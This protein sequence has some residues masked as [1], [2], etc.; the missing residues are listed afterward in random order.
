MIDKIKGWINS[1][2]QKATLFGSIALVMLL[3]IVTISV[4]VRFVG[5][6]ISYE[7]L[8]KK[9]ENATYRYLTEN[10]NNLPSS[11]NPTVAISATTLIEQNYLKELKKYVKDPSC[12][13]NVLVDY[14][15]NDYKYQAYL[16][17]SEFKTEKFVDKIKA[18][19]KISQMGEGLYEMNNELVFRGQN[20]NNFISFA[21]EL[22]RI[23]KI[24]KNN[25]IQM[26]LTETEDDDIYGVWDD[27]YNTEVDSNYGVNNYNL[28]RALIFT[29]QFY[30]TKYK[31]YEDDLTKYDLCVGKRLEDSTDKSGRL[32][33]NEKIQDQEIGLLPLYDYMNASLDAMCQTSISKECQNYNYLV[34]EDSRWWTM[35]ANMKNTHSAFS[36]SIYGEIDSD[37]TSYSTN[38]RYVI[39]LNPSVL[40]KS[41]EGTKENP[42]IIR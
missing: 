33:C 2:K 21:D 37:N 26:I 11:N 27:R 31:K 12:T 17:C 19:N 38:L 36:I 29:K 1:N 13:A 40:Y 14:I 4:T 16:T 3:I 39:A 34:N 41:G 9:L 5:I 28:S 32:E 7:E 22:W 8:E 23:V 42:Y 18:N 30:D 10:P 24:D 20:P 6:K 25:T 35:T 15:N